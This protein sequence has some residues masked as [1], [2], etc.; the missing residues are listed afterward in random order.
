MSSTLRR[1]EPR[2]PGI[3]HGWERYALALVTLALL[4]GCSV[5]MH[6]DPVPPP[7]GSTSA[8]ETTG[9]GDDRTDRTD[10]PARP[11]TPVTAEAGIGFTADP[12]TFLLAIEADYWIEHNVAIGPLVQFGL[13]DDDTIVAPTINAKGV[14]DINQ[15]QLERL[16]PYV[17]GGVGFAYIDK[18]GH[19][20]SD[21]G[22]LLDFGFGANVAL[23]DRVSLGTGVL[24]NFLPAELVDE[25]F[26]FS[27]RVLSV[28]F[29]F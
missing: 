18:D 16:K 10:H 26:F 15:P 12:G 11:V 8:S 28:G 24:F 9:P 4:V 22:L 14:F 5:P 25:R 6:Q 21:T 17:E 27:W 23:N 19:D 3:S 7:S 1:S 29:Q 20:D 2:S 13:S